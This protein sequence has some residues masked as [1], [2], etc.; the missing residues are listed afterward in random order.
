MDFRSVLVLNGN[1]ADLAK[2]AISSVP[3]ERISITFRKMDP[4]KVPRGFVID[5][6]LQNLRPVMLPSDSWSFS[7]CSL[8]IF[9]HYWEHSILTLPFLVFFKS[10]SIWIL[11]ANKIRLYWR[12]FSHDTA[13]SLCTKGFPESLLISILKVFTQS[14]LFDNR[15]LLMRWL[16]TPNNSLVYTY[17]SKD[18]PYW[19]FWTLIKIIRHFSKSERFLWMRTW[20]GRWVKFE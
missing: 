9:R 11:D 12:Y 6:E 13:Q 14:I 8:E 17:V 3:T 16:E 5:K 7:W 4:A 20:A 18:Q 19:D 15:I 2:H 1:G 10:L